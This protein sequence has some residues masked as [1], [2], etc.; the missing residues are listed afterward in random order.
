MVSNVVEEGHKCF[1]GIVRG[2]PHAEEGKS[3]FILKLIQKPSEEDM[4]IIVRDFKGRLD[5]DISGWPQG[6]CVLDPAGGVCEGGGGRG[7]IHW[8]DPLGGTGLGVKV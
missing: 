4:L 3:W 6:D 2:V 8:G 5:G 1:S 7:D